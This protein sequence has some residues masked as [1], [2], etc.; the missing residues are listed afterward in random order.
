[1]LLFRYIFIRIYRSYESYYS[2]RSFALRSSFTT[3]VLFITRIN[4]VKLFS[5]Y[6][7]NKN[8]K[9]FDVDRRTCQCGWHVSRDGASKAR[10]TQC[11]VAII[12]LRQELVFSAI[13]SNLQRNKAHVFSRALIITTREKTIL[14]P[15]I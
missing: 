1:M 11:T 8:W 2:V 10:A 12:N 5:R 4:A 14:A 9:Y 7:E 3:D 13:K 15:Y 6:D